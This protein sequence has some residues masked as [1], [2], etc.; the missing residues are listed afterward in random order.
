MNRKMH[1]AN[2]VISIILFIIGAVT[3]NCSTGRL[4]LSGLIGYLLCI[5][6]L[7]IIICTFAV[8]IVLKSEE[9]IDERKDY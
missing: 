9:K 5:L 7:V 3:I 2:F 8:I 4:S 6:A 1:I